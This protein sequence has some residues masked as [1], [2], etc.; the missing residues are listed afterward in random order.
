[1]YALL[2]PHLSCL[3]ATHTCVRSDHLAN[4]NLKVMQIFGHCLRR[5]CLLTYLRQS[6]CVLTV[7]M[8]KRAGPVVVISATF[9][10]PTQHPAPLAFK[11]PIRPFALGR[12]D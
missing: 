1:M 9:D 6:A 12:P 8:H 4:M 2:P 11:F 5:S 7:K 3:S 10:N